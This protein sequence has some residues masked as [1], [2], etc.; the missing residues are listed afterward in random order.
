MA[1]KISFSDKTKS[2][3]ALRQGIRKRKLVFN[4][5]IEKFG[6]ESMDLMHK[7][8]NSSE[9]KGYPCKVIVKNGAIALKVLPM[10][11]GYSKKDHPCKIET[12][13]LETLT[14]KL[15]EP[16][17]LPHIV[18]FLGTFKVS[19][20]AKA[21]RDLGIRN[22]EGVHPR[23]MVLVS[24][25]VGGGSI[26]DW[27]RDTDGKISDYQWKAVIFQMVYSLYILQRRYKLMH[28]DFHYGNILIDTS[29]VPEGHFVYQGLESKE[30][31]CWYVENTG[32]F[33]KIWDFEF[34]MC[35]S[36]KM[37]ILDFRKDTSV[38]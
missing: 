13:V 37:G 36:S 3:I 12:T 18:H 6:M 11:S 25:Y 22:L 29:I 14:T 4:D 24:E 2:L 20:S 21:V 1:G 16:G 17:I 7:V 9:I 28:N 8:S 23:S 30:D 38:F 10:E 19:N 34:C 15:V 32:I 31:Q 35:Y 26:D 27:V 33:P 5:S